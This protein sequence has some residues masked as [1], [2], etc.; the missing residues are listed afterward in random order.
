MSFGN[1]VEEGAERGTIFSGARAGDRRSDIRRP[2]PV[3]RH[4]LDETLGGALRS[5]LT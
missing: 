5:V 1:A 4:R 2:G 3:L